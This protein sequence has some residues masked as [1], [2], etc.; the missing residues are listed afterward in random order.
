MESIFIKSL[1]YLAGVIIGGVITAVSK[2]PVKVSEYFFLKKIEQVKNSL[3]LDEIRFT[4]LHEKRAEVIAEIYKKIV[5]TNN[6]LTKLQINNTAKALDDSVVLVQLNDLLDYQQQSKLYLSE[7]ATKAIGEVIY[8]ILIP[9]T[10]G[11]LKKCGKSIDNL[12]EEVH[13]KTSNSENPELTNAL[14][15]LETEF[16]EILGGNLDVK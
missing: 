6:N 11:L 12:S 2:L 4:R 16:R 7:K 5:E 1:P 8:N 10:V 14:N 15:A 9:L 13:K 3:R